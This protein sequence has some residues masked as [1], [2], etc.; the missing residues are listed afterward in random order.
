VNRLFRRLRVAGSDVTRED[1]RHLAIMQVALR[2]RF[3]GTYLEKTQEYYK[4]NRK[5]L[6]L[7]KPLP[8]RA[9]ELLKY[10]FDQ[11]WLLAHL[12]VLISL[13]GARGL[14]SFFNKEI[15]RA[16]VNVLGMAATN[17]MIGLIIRLVYALGRFGKVLL[18]ACKEAATAPRDPVHWLIGIL[19]VGVIALRQSKCRA[20]A[21]KALKQIVNATHGLRDSVAEVWN[22]TSLCDVPG[23]ILAAVE[24]TT[25][26]DAQFV[27]SARAA[28]FF[29]GHGQ[30]SAAHHYTRPEDIA[31]STARAYVCGIDHSLFQTPRMLLLVAQMLPWLARAEPHELY[32]P[33]D[34]IAGAFPRWKPEKTIQLVD[35]ERK[36]WGIP[37]GP[38]KAEKKP[39]RNAPCPCGSGKK[40]KRC[41]LRITATR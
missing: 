8:V 25:G 36:S 23:A 2:P 9:R 31:E 38:V 14:E 29:A 32:L 39:R 37:S 24:D 18:P 33:E 10:H 6:S 41:C 40:Y 34:E 27:E 30:R 15:K 11:Q 17:G 7:R 20:E 5:L 16:L 26:A 4:R 3:F 19:G 28:L 13:D 12:S 35:A 22:D 1:I 21:K